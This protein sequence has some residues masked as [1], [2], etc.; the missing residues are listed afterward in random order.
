MG[1]DTTQML[2]MVGKS[3]LEKL[4]QELYSWVNFSIWNWQIPIGS[5]LHESLYH[6]C[7][8]QFLFH[9]LELPFHILKPMLEFGV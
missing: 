6:P 9:V 4:L 2:S 1:E 7:S 3:K 8:N 5:I